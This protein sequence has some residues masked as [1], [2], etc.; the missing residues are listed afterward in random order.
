MEL[1][2]GYI[3]FCI[4][5]WDAI[6]DAPKV[7]KDAIYVTP[8]TRRRAIFNALKVEEDAIFDV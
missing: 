6:Y 4:A 2:H 3:I 1:Y 5:G 8:K 7:M